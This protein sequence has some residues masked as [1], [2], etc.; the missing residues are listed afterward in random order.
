MIRVQQQRSFDSVPDIAKEH[1]R[2]HHTAD[3]QEYSVRLDGPHIPPNVGT[4]RYVELRKPQVIKALA[5]HRKGSARL[6]EHLDGEVILRGA[7][8]FPTRDC[9]SNGCAKSLMGSA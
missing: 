6:F 9:S 1:D 8:C 2:R 4:C 3:I 7:Q 5:C